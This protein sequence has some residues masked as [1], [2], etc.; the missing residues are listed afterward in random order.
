LL[1][2]ITPSV[3]V[4]LDDDDGVK[5]FVSWLSPERRRP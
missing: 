4:D 3:T 2:V 5:R 1:V